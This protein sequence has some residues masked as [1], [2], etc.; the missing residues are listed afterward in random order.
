MAASIPGT[1]S[2]AGIRSTIPRPDR[3]ALVG[4]VPHPDGPRA[5]RG[6][7]PGRPRDHHRRRASARV[8]TDK[9]TLGLCSATVGADR[10]R[11]PARRGVRRAALRQAVRR[12]RPQEPVHR[13]PRR[14]PRR[15]RAHRADLGQ[16]RPRGGLPVPDAVH[17]RHGHRR[18]VR[19]DQLG[20]RRDDAGAATAA[21]STSAST[22]PTGPARSSAPSARSS[23]S[24]RSTPTIGWRLGFLIGP[25]I[26]LCIWNAAPAPAGEPAL[27]DHARPRAEAEEN[28]AYIEHEVRELR[29]AAR[30]GRREPGDRDPPAA[31]GRLPAPGQGAVRAVHRRGPSSA[32]R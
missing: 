32:R 12:A 11:L 21:A 15:Q 26:G 8:L 24:T 22:A 30:A 31:A 14:L 20:H 23:C 25:V 17:R 6:L 10:H 16:Q 9:T 28:I 19:R 2:N 7:G 13:H 1:E 29:P 27:A 3:P 5:R 18:R 4:A